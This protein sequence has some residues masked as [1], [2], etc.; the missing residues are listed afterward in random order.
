MR[1]PRILLSGDSALLV[2]FGNDIDEK[3]NNQ[4]R[5]FDNTL[6]KC[7]IAGIVETVPSYRSLMI[8]YNPEIIDCMTLTTQLEELLKSLQNIEI[9]PSQIIEIPVLYGDKFGPDI[10]TVATHNNKTIEE[11]IHIHTSK[12]YLIYM[13]GFTPGFPYL[14]GMSEKIETPRREKPRIKISGGSVGI[15]GK[16]TGIYPIDSP[17]GWQIIGKTPL[18]LYNEKR[19]NPILLRAGQYIKFKSISEQEFDQI[20]AQIEKEIYQHNIY[21]RGEVT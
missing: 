21:L 19:E 3:V 13:L 20:T 8:I 9:P 16:Q 11:V 18:K 2:E 15:A 4:L 10:Q 7:A 6:K 17:G 12:E 1:Y 14:G 5:A